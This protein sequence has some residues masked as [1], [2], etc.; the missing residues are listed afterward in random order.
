MKLGF[1][2]WAIIAGYFIFVLASGFYFKNKNSDDKDYFLG[3]RNV[4]W[5]LISMSLVA[6]QI[7]AVTIIG[8][9]G[10]A[11]KD[12]LQTAAMY[13]VIPIVM[14]Y[15]GG[16]LAPF[17]YNSKVS[18]IHEYLLDRFG[19]KMRLLMVI[20]Y[21]LKVIAVQ[22][23][24]TYVPALVLSQITGLNIIITIVLITTISIIS[25]AMGGIKAAIWSDALQVILIWTALV[26]SIFLLI[27]AL[28]MGFFNALDIA[29]E[30][31]KL[32]AIDFNSDVTSTKSIFA[33][34]IGGAMAHLGYFGT[35]QTQVQK[36][37]TAK[38][39]KNLKTSLWVSGVVFVIQILLF[40]TMGSL[41]YVY[42]NGATFANSDQVFIK[43]IV[44]SMPVGIIGIMIAAIFSASSL[45]SAL[46]PIA[47]VFVKDIYEVYID[48]HVSGKKMLK[49]SRY[50]T[51]VFGVLFAGFAYIQSFAKLSVLESIGKYGSYILGS[52][53]GV[54]LLGIYTKKTNEKGA[55]AGFISGF[56]AVVFV[57]TQ[58]HIT[59]LW[60]TLI[61]TVVT[62]TAGYLVSIMTGGEK[63][64]IS[65][66]TIKGQKA[67]FEKNN[68][69]E[70]E[71]G[72]YILP[73]KFEKVSY[74]AFIFFIVVM[75]FLYLLGR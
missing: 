24:I 53:L 51:L 30:A 36:M 47:T 25:T 45:G 1:I 49:I 61:G 31:G 65:I 41:L 68:I 70:M 66:Y 46:N 73:G 43:F 50:S 19:S 10:W 67:Y 3:G 12:G 8:G 75:I 14:F 60:N 42:Y 72:I 33:A 71:D 57:A 74:F 17:F 38:S 7:S 34:I 16:V 59:W 27:K 48:K 28:P 13:L 54:F 26:C 9:P 63:K 6:T 29:K 55:V 20:T 18:S 2:D 4:G 39:M 35:D 58:M 21:L 69:N 11:Y 62:L 23:T 44:T 5:G 15:L 22:G 37:L 32:T 56:L 64:D 40:T 52:M